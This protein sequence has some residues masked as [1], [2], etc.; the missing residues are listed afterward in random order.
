MAKKFFVNMSTN[1]E[2]FVNAAGFLKILQFNLNY[3]YN[4]FLCTYIYIMHRAGL[5]MASGEKSHH[6]KRHLD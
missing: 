1:W 2:V 5:T 3:Y 4:S 6:N